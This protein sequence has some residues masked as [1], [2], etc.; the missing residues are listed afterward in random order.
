MEK[1]KYQNTGLSAAEVEESRQQHGANV[2]T[3]PRRRSM[4]ALYL[5]KYEDPIVRILLV[6]AAA[7][8]VLACFNGEFVETIGIILA[9]FFATTV[10]FYFERD[11][12]R[13]FDLLTQ[14]G[15]EQQVKVVREG[16][17]RLIRRRD[18]VVGDMVIVETG[19]EVPADGE[20]MESNTLEVDESSLT[21]E[22]IAQKHAPEASEKAEE[23]AETTY[24]P[25]LLL[26]SSMVMSGSGVYRVSAVGDKTEI[27]RVARM[28]TELTQ[29]K[30]PLNLQLS[31]LA[32]LISKAGTAVSTVAFAAFLLHDVLTN[33]LW[34][35]TDYMGMATVV[36]RYFMM[37]VTL[38]VM[39]VPE[40]LPM[41]ITLALALN[42]RRMLRSGN[43]V[44]KLQASETM[45]AVTVICTDKTGTLTENRM[46]VEEMVT[47]DHHEM[48]KAIALNTTAHLQADGTG[49]GNPTEVALL[50]WVQQ[51]G[52][53]YEQLR[54]TTTIDE[55]LPF[56]TERK[57]MATRV[58]TRIYIK[59]APEMVLALCGSLEER[60]E[61]RVE[62]G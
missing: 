60:E 22:P 28:A 50:R 5:E 10:G 36:L 45:G 39:A 25:T 20:L 53:D 42:M 35:T 17:V 11:A 58:R 47:D 8:L 29:V 14:L 59:G 37:A 9:I 51:E 13:K 57:L 26:R 33:A 49:I 34:H 2:L 1:G 12:A 44:R 24:P 21:G 55:R 38:I 15:E 40:G 48:A 43:L 46:R 4:W 56:S 18:V 54:Q 7:S 16:E 62:R 52:F 31:R 3:P 41:A 61:R 27:G 6:A 30:T 32:A 19:D 23:S